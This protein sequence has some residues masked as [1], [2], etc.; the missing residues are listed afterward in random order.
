MSVFGFGDNPIFDMEEAKEQTGMNASETEVENL[1]TNPNQFLQDNSMSLSDQV[2]DFKID[3]DSD[4]KTTVDDFGSIADVSLT[5][6][7]VDE[8]GMTDVVAPTNPGAST[9][10]A[11][12]VEEQL[13]TPE[14]TVNAAQGTINENQDLMDASTIEI[15]VAAEGQGTGVLGNAL[16]DYASQNMSTIIDTS[17]IHG[18]LLAEQLG[19]GNY[20]DSKAT[21][22]GQ[23]KILGNEFVDGQGNTIIPSWAQGAARS[24]NRLMAFGDVTGTAALRATSNAIMEATL[25][26]ADKEAAFFQTLT[27]ENLSNK[28]E[29][30]INKTK[31][32]ASFEEA[33]LTA[34]QAALKHNAQAFLDMNLANVDREQEAEVINTQERIQVMLSDA[35]E[36]NLARRFAAEEANDLQT[37]Y[38]QLDINTQ[39]WM[40]EQLFAIKSFNVGEKNAAKQFVAELN[41]LQDRF[42]AEQQRLIDVDNAGWRR[43]VVTENARVE[44]EVAAEDVKNALD[45]SQEALNRTW[46]RIDSEL[47]YIFKG[48]DNESD[49]DAEI[50]KATIAAQAEVDANSQDSSITSALFKLASGYIT[51]NR[52]VSGVIDDVNSVLNVFGLG[53]IGAAAAGTTAAGTAAAGTAAAGSGFLASLGSTAA[54]VAPWAAAAAATYGLYELGQELD[55]DLNPFDKG[56][57]LEIDLLDIDLNPFDDGPLE[58]DLFDWRW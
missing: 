41:S 55:V 52:G 58:I 6:D 22:L 35:G 45:I 18:K 17:T 32:L 24:V 12:T 53:G 5:P 42:E 20:V 38:D 21:I 54:A 47:D 4:P 16:N 56:E 25:G 14:T 44:L 8:T 19:D 11:A 49:R 1:A 39:T 30:I 23:M 3:A 51:S 29:S 2:E 43:E 9:Y 10:T 28:Q 48:W 36:K 57:D 31:I 37:F 15:D 13:G 33:N 50:L 7:Q 26:V 40:K 27:T 34:R 46:N